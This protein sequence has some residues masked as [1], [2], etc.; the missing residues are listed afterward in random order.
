[1]SCPHTSSGFS[2]LSSASQIDWI[3]PAS[4]TRP[5]CG[6]SAAWMTAS[7]SLLSSAWLVYAT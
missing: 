1:M 6:A 2:A 7:T 4:G 5:M 3:T